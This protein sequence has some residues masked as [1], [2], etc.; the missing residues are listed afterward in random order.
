MPKD[1]N[2]LTELAQVPVIVKDGQVIMETED[3][4][5]LKDAALQ[6]MASAF[7][8]KVEYKKKRVVYTDLEVDLCT[9][10]NCYRPAVEGKL[11]CSD[12][13]G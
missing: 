5:K 12:H 6:I 3:L 1:V 8:G 4:L 13:N 9:H 7:Q 10:Y 11:S 2:R